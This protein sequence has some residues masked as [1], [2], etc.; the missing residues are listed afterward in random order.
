[1]RD[2]PG[3]AAM[4]ASRPL[5]APPISQ[6]GD[7]RW[8][9]HRRDRPLGLPPSDCNC[10]DKTRIRMAFGSGDRKRGAGLATQ[11]LFAGLSIDPLAY[12]VRMTVVSCVLA[13]QLQQVPSQTVTVAGADRVKVGVGLN[14][15]VGE[16]LFALPGRH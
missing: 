15:L 3:H 11:G 13:D 9:C 5:A 10:D 8:H 1:M 14:P 2:H 7:C 4:L 12:Q 6:T 16:V